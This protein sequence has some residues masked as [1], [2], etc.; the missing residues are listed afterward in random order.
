MQLRRSRVK[1]IFLLLYS[2]RIEQCQEQFGAVMIWAALMTSGEK[3]G[4][5]WWNKKAKD[6]SDVLCLIREIS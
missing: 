6:A 5:N 1:W 4:P 2:L 3:D